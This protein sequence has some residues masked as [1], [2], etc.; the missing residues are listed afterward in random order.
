M[1]ISLS[2]IGHRACKRVAYDAMP[3]LLNQMICGNL[4]NRNYEPILSQSGDTVNIPLIPVMSTNCMNDE[5]ER[6]PASLGNAQIVLS[7]HMESSFRVPDIREAL[8]DPDLLKTYIYPSVLALVESIESALIS[9]ASQFTANKPVF[10]DPGN[11]EPALDAVE[12]ALFYAK[13]PL[14][15]PKHLIVDPVS[16]AAISSHPR[17]E[18]GTFKDLLV[19]CTPLMRSGDSKLAI[20]K[21]AIALVTRRLPTSIENCG[22]QSVYAETKDFG[23]CVRLQASADLSKGW[24]FVLEMLFGVGVLRN[25]FGVELRAA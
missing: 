5:S 2:E 14:S 7:H 4:V 25:S 6:R 17:F 16:Y 22:W 11:V 13:V 8:V 3:Q 18:F 19:H 24:L 15:I 10:M 12:T 21:D 23:F 9:V 1:N 20:A